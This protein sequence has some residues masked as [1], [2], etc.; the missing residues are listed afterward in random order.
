MAKSSAAKEQTLT[1]PV[2]VLGID[3][4]YEPAT[5]SAYQYREKYVYPHLASKGYAIDRCQGPLAKRIYV[6]PKAQQPGVAY[7]TGVGHG[8]YTTYTGH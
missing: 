2:S 5:L 7:L 1:V 4:N 3:S 6:A 8:S